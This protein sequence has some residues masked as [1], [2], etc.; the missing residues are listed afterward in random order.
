M[1]IEAKQRQSSGGQPAGAANPAPNASVASGQPQP[2]VPP[3]TQV[4]TPPVLTGPFQD[5]A[6]HP[7]PFAAGPITAKRLYRSTNE[8]M[9]AGVCGGIAE[10]FNADPVVVRLITV[11]LA[12]ITAFAPVAIAYVI[13]WLI[14]PER[15]AE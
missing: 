1:R 11:L 13:A 14:I 15:P 5:N 12:L 7:A 10:Y 9:I 2:H 6:Q 3:P 4:P 8:K